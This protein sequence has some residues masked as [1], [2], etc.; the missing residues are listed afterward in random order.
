MLS[1]LSTFEWITSFGFICCLTYICGWLADGLM[2]RSAYGH[3]GNWLF[4]LI[5][6]YTAIYVF[7]T[8]GYEFRYDPLFTLAYVSAGAALFF[9]FFCM[10]K[11]VFSR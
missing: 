5:G 6:T 4:L 9:L 10:T 7:N 1:Q 11:R 3:I 2:K 8:Y